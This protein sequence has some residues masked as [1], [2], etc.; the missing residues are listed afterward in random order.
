MIEILVLYNDALIS[1]T[2]STHSFIL[3]LGMR[4]ILLTRLTAL[5]LGLLISTLLQEH[6]NFLAGLAQKVEERFVD[7]GT[8][9][10]G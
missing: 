1:T 2:P 8:A 5:S 4:Q 3:V 10:A 7:V 6:A 9:H